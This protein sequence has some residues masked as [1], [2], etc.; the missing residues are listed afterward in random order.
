MGDRVEKAAS[1]ASSLDAEQ[2]SDAKTQGRYGHDIE[3][4]TASTLI[5]TTS[6]NLTA[7][8]PVTTV[9]APV[10]TAGVYVSTAEPSTHP[11]TK[12]KTLIEDEDLTI[13]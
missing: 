2:D 4:N 7:V 11:P 8:E 3:V 9:S 10:T 5:T 12:T 6:I 13:A 1:T